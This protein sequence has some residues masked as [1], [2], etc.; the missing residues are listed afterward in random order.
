[1]G[2]MKKDIGQT[3]MIAQRKGSGFSLSGDEIGQ[4]EKEG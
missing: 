1:M 4:E 3:V 2:E